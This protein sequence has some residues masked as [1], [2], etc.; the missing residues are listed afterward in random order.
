MNVYNN[1]RKVSILQTSSSKN[2]D[3][4]LNEKEDSTNKKNQFKNNL[5]LVKEKDI[6]NKQTDNENNS[7]KKERKMMIT[8]TGG[9]HF[10]CAKLD[11][12]V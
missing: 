6:L 10:V 11:I 7:N 12:S 1:I 5:V 9:F 8:K 4:N 2:E 3:K